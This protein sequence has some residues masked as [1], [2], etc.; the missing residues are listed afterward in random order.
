MDNVA[1]LA[2]VI[3]RDPGA[4]IKAVESTMQK[5]EQ[6]GR[7]ADVIKSTPNQFGALRGSDR[8]VD[9][10]ATAG[11]EQKA[12]LAAVETASVHVRFAAPALSLEFEKAT[13]VEDARRAR[14]RVEVPR[15]SQTATTAIDGLTKIKDAVAFDAA[16]KALPDTTKAELRAFET[17]LSKR[18]GPNVSAGD[19]AALASVP[20]QQRKTFEAVRETLKTVSRAIDTDRS[21]RIAQERLAQV[22][23][24]KK[25]ISR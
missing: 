7:L 18:L 10:F 25:G 2:S 11:A 8:L 9:R 5:P 3:W 21:Q 17:A 12:A 19:R 15:L 4:A 16:V 14:M 23:K 24:K 20:E 1:A 13:V 22:Q 6:R